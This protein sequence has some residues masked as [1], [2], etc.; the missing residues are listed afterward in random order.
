M[1]YYGDC[2]ITQTFSKDGQEV[3]SVNY[4]KGSDSFE[5]TYIKTSSVETYSDIESTASAIKKAV[6][7]DSNRFD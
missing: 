2:H 3:L 4:I 1:K 5:V 6:M 7:N